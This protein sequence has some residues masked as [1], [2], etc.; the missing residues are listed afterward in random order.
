MGTITLAGFL[1][2]AGDFP[3][4][5]RSKNNDGFNSELLTSE[6]RSHAP[7]WERAPDAPASMKEPRR[8]VISNAV[9]YLSPQKRI[10]LKIADSQISGSHKTC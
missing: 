2:W 3:T 5:G 9:R 10:R 6:D 8:P 4:P 1:E 7:A